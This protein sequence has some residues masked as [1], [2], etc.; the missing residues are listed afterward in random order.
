[1]SAEKHL[2]NIFQTKDVVTYGYDGQLILPD[3][4][5]GIVSQ[6]L[7][8]HKNQTHKP[9]QSYR[10]IYE[11][12]AEVVMLAGEAIRTLLIGFPLNAPIVLV[13]LRPSRHWV[14]ALPGIVRRI[15]QRQVSIQGVYRNRTVFQGSWLVLDNKLPAI[16]KNDTISTPN[17]VGDIEA[18]ITYLNKEKIQY[19]ILRNYERLPGLHREHGDIDFL[20]ED[21]DI[22][23]VRA[24]LVDHPGSQSI[25]IHAVSVPKSKVEAVPYLPP[26]QARKLIVERVP[27]RCQ[28]W[29]PNPQF[30][31]HSYAY[32][33]VYNKGVASG[34]PTSYPGLPVSKVLENDYLTHVKRLAQEAGVEDIVFT[35]EGLDRYLNS[36]G[37]RPHADT[38][39]KL[40]ERNIWI[41]KHFFEEGESDEE[42]SYVVMILRQDDLS[43]EIKEQIFNIITSYGFSIVFN[44][45][46]VGKYK[47][48]AEESL[49]GGVWVGRDELNPSAYLPSDFLVVTDLFT[50]HKSKKLFAHRVRLLK[51]KIRQSLAHLEHGS[52]LIHATDSTTEAAEY[53][54]TVFP[55]ETKNIVDSIKKLQDKKLTI[56][57]QLIDKIE[58]YRYVIKNKLQKSKSALKIRII[59]YIFG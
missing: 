29:I 13:S 36:V 14:Y 10:D 33:C 18:F 27:G 22:T 55:K 37:W 34:I 6:Y 48:L 31:F 49:R 3:K 32:H 52:S 24:Y 7:Q 44:Q 35:M 53:I 57:I 16:T 51:Q 28:S 30:A 8:H 9:Y 19:V 38:L 23:K 41:Q 50:M 42:V 15:L 56:S 11:S 5:T 46:L 26:K 43:T 4:K 21:G 59:N 12:K 2:E 47:T 20:V 58:L 1:M 39:I 17:S 25:G 54:D 40:S 45:Q